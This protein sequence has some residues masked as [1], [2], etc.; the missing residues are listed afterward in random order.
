MNIVLVY[1]LSFFLEYTGELCI[2]CIKKKRRKEPPK[3]Q[4]QKGT[5]TR[6]DLAQ[7]NDQH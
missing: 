1:N 5:L 2:I 3:E 4:I 7:Q 6:L